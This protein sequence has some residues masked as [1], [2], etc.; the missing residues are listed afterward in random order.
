MLLW[1]PST[2]PSDDAPSR[3]YGELR[4]GDEID[5]SGEATWIWQRH[6]FIQCPSRVERLNQWASDNEW[7]FFIDETPVDAPREFTKCFAY[8]P[9]IFHSLWKIGGDLIYKSGFAKWFES[10]RAIR[11]DV[12]FLRAGKDGPIKIG[13]AQDTVNRMGQLQ[14]GCA[15][16]IEVLGTIENG[17]RK[18]EAKLHKQFANLRMNGEWFEPRRELI[19]FIQSTATKRSRPYESS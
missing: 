17:G 5:I 14:C 18:L 19:E 12:Y 8:R 15:W 3:L 11:Q 1:S 10:H 4:E 6:Q 7:C 13:I 16:P 9:F 2:M